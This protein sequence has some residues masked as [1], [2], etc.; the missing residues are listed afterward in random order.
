MPSTLSTLK[1]PASKNDMKRPASGAVA[2]KAGSLNRA[3]EEMKKGWKNEEDEETTK[4]TQ[5]GKKTDGGEKGDDDEDEDEEGGE[6]EDAKRDK[7][8]SVK[9]QSMKKNLPPHIVQ[10]YE[11]EALNKSSPRQFRT[12]IINSLFRKLSNGR[13]ELITDQP[14]FNEYKKLYEKKYGREAE[15]GYPRSVMKGLYFQNDEVAFQAAI[16]NGEVYQIEQGGKEFFAFQSVETGFERPTA[17][18][19]QR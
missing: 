19:C 11:Q 9:F 6:G 15:K 3:V 16:T 13:Y 2:T 12:T 8:K 7:G 1:R 14:M 18:L 5:K 10:L 4:K 17:V